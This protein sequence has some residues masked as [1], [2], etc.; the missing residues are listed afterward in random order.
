MQTIKWRY[1]W[2]YETQ[3]YEGE[4]WV[5]NEDGSICIRPTPGFSSRL[6]IR[7]L[8]ERRYDLGFSFL[9]S[10]DV[11]FLRPQQ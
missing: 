3:W 4:R 2:N 1:E 11:V 7:Q 5:R 9:K 6:E 8:A 10:A